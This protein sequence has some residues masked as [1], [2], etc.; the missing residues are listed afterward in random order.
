[1]KM[2]AMLACVLGVLIAQGAGQDRSQNSD[3]GEGADSQA[4]AA[5]GGT[6]PA[7]P[8]DGQGTTPVVPITENPPLSAVDLPAVEPHAAPISYLQPGATVSESADS[9]IG[10]SLGNGGGTHSVTRGLGSLALQRVWRNYDLSL[11]YVGGVG[12]YNIT[13]QGLRLLQQMDFEQ[14]WTWKRGNFALRDSFSYLPEGD[15]GAAYG[16]LGS[17]GIASLGSTA[18]SSFWGGTGLGTLGLEP[19]ILN[20]SLA[21][22]TE[23]LTPKSAV[24]A[25]GGYAFTHFY[26]NP[27]QTSFIGTAPGEGSLIGSSQFSGQTAYDRVLTPR[28]QVAVLW[29]YQRFDFTVLGTQFHSNIV[30]LMYGHRIS[31]RMDFLI[32]AGPQFTNIGI[33]CT[34]V[35]LLEGNPH[36][37]TNPAGNIVGTIP[38]FRIGASGR[39][40][41]RYRFRKTALDLNYERYLT[42]GSGFFAGA[43]T[44]VARL[45][46]DR[47]LSRVW[48]VV[49]DMGYA[50]NSNEQ[51]LT[52]RAEATCAPK[53]NP[54]FATEVCPGFNANAYTYGFVG[55]GLHR[56]FGRELH[57]F[58]SYQFNELAFDHSYCGGLPACSRIGSR[59]IVTF[60]LD[61]TP[62]PMRID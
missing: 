26:G 20:V 27:I 57:G 19:R 49:A 15:F 30:Q 5:D 51:P 38:E 10:N 16:A 3:R 17:E 13:N 11:D 18:F 52:A 62:R 24:T 6:Q 14:K 37:G 31:G 61:W 35:S 41:L 36:C 34:L 28:T 56:A 60:G 40:R 2:V 23:D 4:G 29:G 7:V 33:A 22:L 43:E 9:N 44:D 47:P 55:A 21:Q 53:V 25:A 32:G 59:Q 42:S 48:G 39:A 1:M 58:F 45:S 12:Y 54:F 50:K 8:L 46:A